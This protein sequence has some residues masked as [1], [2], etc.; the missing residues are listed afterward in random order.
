M[1][2][3]PRGFNAPSLH[4]RRFME[5]KDE[6]TTAKAE[7]TTK[8]RWQWLDHVT[9]ERLKKEREREVAIV[10]RRTTSQND[11]PH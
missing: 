2:P 11:P 6:A 5:G 9:E 1:V 10:I 3:E 4:Q 8:V 7:R